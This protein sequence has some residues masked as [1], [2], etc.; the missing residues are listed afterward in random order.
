MLNTSVYVLM[1]IYHV[2]INTHTLYVFA[3]TDVPLFAWVQILCSIRGKPKIYTVLSEA[4]LNLYMTSKS[5]TSICQHP[6]NLGKSEVG[7][8]KIFSFKK[9][10]NTCGSKI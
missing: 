5:F 7:F 9:P 10:I 8:Y 2:C 4:V 6:F 1:Y 3:N